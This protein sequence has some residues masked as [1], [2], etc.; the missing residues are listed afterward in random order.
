[1]LAQVLM[2]RGVNSRTLPATMLA[3]EIL[4]QVAAEQSKIICI[5]ALPPEAMARTR[6]LCKRLK[7]RFPQVKIVVG[8]WDAQADPARIGPRLRQAGADHVSTNLA[9]MLQVVS[10]SHRPAEVTA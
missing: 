1:M 4:E 9:E 8:F 7:A 2:D 10:P 6:Y 5:S 3:G